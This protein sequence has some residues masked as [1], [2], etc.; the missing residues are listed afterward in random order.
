MVLSLQTVVESDDALAY[1]LALQHD[2]S[3][4]VMVYGSYTTAV[5]AGGNNPNETGTPDPYDQEETG[6]LELGIKE[7]FNGWCL[8]LNATYFDNTTDGMLISSIVNAGSKNN[9]VDAE[10]QGFEGNMVFFLNE[11]TKT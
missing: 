9:N 10:I 11:S 6:V 2:L 3:D 4:D 7:Y 1:K 8:L 5:K